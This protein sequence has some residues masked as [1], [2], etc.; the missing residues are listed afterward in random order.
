MRTGTDRI[1]DRRRAGG[2]GT[3]N[4]G[5][6]DR[7]HMGGRTAGSRRLS[8]RESGRRGKRRGNF[9][10]NTRWKRQLS[11]TG[12]SAR[13]LM[14]VLAGLL[15]M[16]FLS[17]VINPGK[18][19]IFAVFGL[20]FLPLFIVNLVLFL[21]ALKRR[22]RSFVIPLAALLPSVFFIGG[23]F[24]LPSSERPGTPAEGE[25]TVRL[26]SY[27]VGRFLQ[28]HGRNMPEGRRACSDSIRHFL[29]EQ[30]AD[31]ICLQEFYTTDIGRVRQYLSG[32]LKGY[33][34]E[35]YFYRSRYGY[36]GNVTFSRM[37]ARDKGVIHFDNSANLAIYT[38]Y[39]Y[40]GKS[41]RVYNCHFESYNIS[42]TGLLRSVHRRDR[43]MLRETE[44][45]VRRGLAQ[46]PRQ[47][48][49]VLKHIAGSPVESFVCGDFN[50]TPMSY[51]YYRLSKGSDDSFRKAGEW[52]GATFSF[53]WPLLRIDYVLY[54]EEFRAISHR[55]PHR[56]YSDHYPVVT[57][58]SLTAPDGSGG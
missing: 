5:D 9:R 41:F 23:Y 25:E 35:Y 15:V 1:S 44:T 8:G 49:R 54:P 31:I 38:D 33:R 52:F 39:T 36:Y 24:Q 40:K 57:E 27:N 34:A 17:V 50:D 58:I 55:T 48:S 13:I 4:G 2:Q 18:V 28:S 20:L 26:V 29:T 3:D 7:R 6:K 11:F 42:T 47:V 46:R 32:W 43:E 14:S 21:W 10:L 22:S 37:R 56:P 45:K 16:S 53:L 19:W 51:T 30:N 12:V